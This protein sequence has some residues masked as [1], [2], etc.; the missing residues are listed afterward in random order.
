MCG[1]AGIISKQPKK[2][3]ASITKMS[4]AIKDRGPD[5]EG[6][7]FF[8]RKKITLANGDTSAKS[9][10]SEFNYFAESHVKSFSNL[11]SSVA[12][13]HR[14]LS[15]LDLS[16]RGHQPMC[17]LSGN[18]W[19]IFNGEIYN[20]AE[21]RTFLQS[22]GFSF[23]TQTDTEVVLYAYMFWGCEFL[24]KLNGMFAFAILDK[25]KNEIF[26]ARDRIGIKPL[27]FYSDT[28]NF[29]FASNIRAIVSSEL[30][31]KEL[32]KSALYQNFAFGFSIKPQTVFQNILM[33]EPGYYL[34]VNL[35]NLKIE[36][37]Q[38][39]ELP[40]GVEKLTDEN[41]LKQKLEDLLH[42]SIKLRL[43]SDTEVATFLSGGIDSG[44]LTTIANKYHPQIKAFTLSFDE[45]DPELIRSKIISSAN[46][47]NQK[48][49]I[50]KTDEVL[51]H[52][53]EIA[54][55]Y[56]EPF[57]QMGPTYMLAKSVASQNIKV[58]LVGL[59]PDEIFG[60]YGY[61]NS[62][63][64]WKYIRHI[65]PLIKLMPFESRKWQKV[66]MNRHPKN[67]A[68]IY[69]LMYMKYPENLVK[70]LFV[71]DIKED[72]ISAP[73]RILNPNNLKFA[74]PMEAFNFF[75]LKM[76][77]NGHALY[78]GDQFFMN[79]GLESRVPFLDHRIVELSF[80]ISDKLKVKNK[81][82]KYILKSMSE[83]YLPKEII[84]KK[85][86]GFNLPLYKWLQGDMR[87][88]LLETAKDIK[89]MGI[90]DAKTVDS[91]VNSDIY[92]QQWHL[93]MFKTWND[94]YFK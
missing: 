82:T 11:D 16:E 55:N 68:E 3:S 7:L 49:A 33:L 38:Y 64:R 89:E 24:G 13:A 94:L 65:T 61:Y 28:E 40:V 76:F 52:L 92:Y 71:D 81:Q 29:V 18:Y 70:K 42:D 1:I 31:K 9:K 79:F 58:V 46:K 75:D 83:K 69:A 53:K 5:D 8:D 2:L 27:F 10:T 6:Y 62:L 88:Y 12:F 84:Y 48:S 21:I 36:K 20:F 72:I 91:I 50:I 32:N 34:R 47:L 4:D 14:R 86:L 39:W 74:S 57:P 30:Y 87:D 17:D 73:N 54:F 51:N 90:F 67:W 43:I 35:Q 77:L 44:L 59:G 15:I 56:E 63:N 78:H 19:I 22:K 66:K 37:T 25:K 85:K 45:K 26:I 60:G 41:F 93:V 80:R 23:R